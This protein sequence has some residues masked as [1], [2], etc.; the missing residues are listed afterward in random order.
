MGNRTKQTKRVGKKT[1]KKAPIEEAPVVDSPVKSA[2]AVVS[3]DEIRK[4]KVTALRDLLTERGLDSKGKKADLLKRLGV[5]GAKAPPSKKTAVAK[6]DSDVISRMTVAELTAELKDAGLSTTGAKPA[7]IARLRKHRA[8][9]GATPARGKG[10]TKKKVVIS[11]PV[12]DHS[13]ERA[14]K[15][16][17]KE[18][19]QKV[20]ETFISMGVMSDPDDSEW[21]ADY[22]LAKITGDSKALEFLDAMN[23]RPVEESEVE[24]ETPIVE[25]ETPAEEVESEEEESPEVKTVDYSVMSFKELKALASSRGLSAKGKKADLMSRLVEADATSEEV[26]DETPAEVESEE[27][28]ILVETVDYSGMSFKDLKALTSSRGLSAKGKKADLV[29]RLTKADE[30]EADAV[31]EESEAD[32]EKETL[33]IHEVEGHEGLFTDGK[34]QFEKVDGEWTVIG[35]FNEE[36]PDRSSLLKPEDVAELEENSVRYD[37]SAVEAEAVEEV[38]EEESDDADD[39]EY[40]KMMDEAE[41][42]DEE[43][44]ESEEVVI[45]DEEDGDVADE[46]SED[47]DDTIEEIEVSE[48]D[49]RKFV[50]VITSGKASIK[51]IPRVAKACGLSED[52][53]IQIATDSKKYAAMYPSVTSSNKK[54]A[55][56]GGKKRIVG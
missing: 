29:H 46:A 2:P 3:D 28:E 19:V 47:I 14:E 56:K 51:D 31:A 9:G 15:S 22:A 52:V 43:S 24:E 16:L 55:K 38:D 8:G 40:Q 7:K 23:P 49:Y 13:C 1:A 48:E 6:G 35:L 25:E 45:E 44:E 34:W 32:E 30:L 33:K 18:D 11:E 12:S 42:E 37:P 50:D 26:S 21:V 36:T 20:M 53:V 54:V 5:T 4:M 17:T 41:D 39:D 27:E 10:Q